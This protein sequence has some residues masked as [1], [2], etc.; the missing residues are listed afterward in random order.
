MFLTAYAMPFQ[1]GNQFGKKTRGGGRP[2]AYAEYGRAKAL[3]EAFFDGFDADEAIKLLKKLRVRTNKKGDIIIP[4]Q[5]IGKVRI[6]DVFLAK[7]VFRNDK[8]LNEIMKKLLPDRILDETPPEESPAK[9]ILEALFKEKKKAKR[10]SN[11]KEK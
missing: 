9:L 8:L 11:K 2:S 4:K 7:A 1:K 6:L 10:K 3:A 5:K